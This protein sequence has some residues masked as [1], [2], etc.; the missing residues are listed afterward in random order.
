MTIKKIALIAL[1]MISF[2]ANAAMPQRC[3]IAG[4]SIQTFVYQS[5]DKIA[6]QS[7][8]TANLLPTMANIA[9][10]NISSTG[11]RMASSGVTGYGLISNL[12]SLFYT[13]GSITPSCIV[14]ALGTNDWTSSGQA[15]DFIRSYRQTV[16]YSKALGM[17]VVC[18]MPTWRRDEGTLI[19]H[20]DGNYTIEQYRYFVSEVCFGEGVH[21]FDTTQIGLLPSDFADGLHMNESGHRKYAAALMSDLIAWGIIKQ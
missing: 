10:T 9:I 2:Y 14:I 1:A 3:I 13:S 17:N 15:I 18:A 7:Q 6:D 5:P 12:N 16:Q 20:P 4:D 8:L 11:Q 21:V 19:A